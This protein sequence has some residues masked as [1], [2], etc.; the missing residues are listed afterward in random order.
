M[1][2]IIIQETDKFGR[3]L[4]RHEASAPIGRGDASGLADLLARGVGSLLCG[5][6]VSAE[7][8]L[9]IA[10]GRTYGASRCTRALAH[11]AGMAGSVMAY[12]LAVTPVVDLDRLLGY[13]A[14]RQQRQSAARMLDL[15]GAEVRGGVGRD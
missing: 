8:P 11:A 1:I 3:V 9:I 13:S 12:G 10:A 5:D 15:W 6:D 4:A 14:S 7:T 2:T